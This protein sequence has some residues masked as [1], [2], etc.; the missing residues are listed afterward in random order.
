MKNIYVVTNLIGNYLKLL[1][2]FYFP[3]IVGLQLHLLYYTYRIPYCI[4]SYKYYPPAVPNRLLYLTKSAG[5][6]FVIVRCDC[7]HQLF[8]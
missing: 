3:P 8:N 7:I 6:S 5:H 2:H 1:P 4:L